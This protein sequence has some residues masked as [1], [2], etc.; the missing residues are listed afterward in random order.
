[1]NN[2]QL[3]SEV[4]RETNVDVEKQIPGRHD[5]LPW[6][7]ESKVLS[8][9]KGHSN[10]SVW[11]NWEKLSRADDIWSWS[12]RMGRSLPFSSLEKLLFTGSVHTETEWP[13]VKGVAGGLLGRQR[14]GHSGDLYS[15]SKPKIVKPSQAMGYYWAYIY[16]TIHQHLFAPVLC[17]ERQM[18]QLS[19][20]KGFTPGSRR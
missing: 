14:T 12:W 13:P 16:V 5:D 8:D 1:M 4:S 2:V 9:C 18:G 11:V 7:G 3:S 19:T 17:L 10:W 15:P 20:P 6:R